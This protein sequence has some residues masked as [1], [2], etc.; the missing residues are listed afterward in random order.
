MIKDELIMIREDGFT[1]QGNDATCNVPTSLVGGGG[2]FVFPH[3]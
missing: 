3:R 1:D 2:C